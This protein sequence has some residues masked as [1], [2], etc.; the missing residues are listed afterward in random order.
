[1]YLKI[2]ELHHSLQD[3]WQ[4]FS[5]YRTSQE[6]RKSY[7]KEEKLV[8]DFGAKIEAITMDVESIKEHY[9]AVKE[10]QNNLQKTFDTLK[11]CKIK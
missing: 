11:V 1:M 10:K 5:E 4:N 7:E 3:L 2:S 6:A 9:D 8:A